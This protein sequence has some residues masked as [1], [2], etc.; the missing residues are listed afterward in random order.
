MYKD[1]LLALDINDEATWHKALPVA[2]EL[3]RNF[4][5]N[6]HVLTVVPDFGMSIVA[7]HFPADFEKKALT[8]AKTRLEALVGESLDDLGNVRLVVEQGSVHKEIVA[9]AKVVGADLIVI[10]SSKPG[11][12][13]Y[14]LGPNAA[15]V[16][17]QAESSVLVVRD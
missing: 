7:Q 11:L 9:A 6:L 5:A 8:E 13:D 1:I 3:R 10:S 2:D 14:L 4:A 16:V 12:R 15:Q 17:R